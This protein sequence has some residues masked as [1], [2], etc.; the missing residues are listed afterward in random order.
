M[1]TLLEWFATSIP[2][3]LGVGGAVGNGDIVGAGLSDGRGATVGEA[4]FGVFVG[5]G[6][7]DGL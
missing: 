1:S 2:P 6:D 4:W 5:I 3:A 7:G